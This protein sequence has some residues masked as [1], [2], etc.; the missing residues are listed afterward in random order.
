VQ[1][2]G[3]QFDMDSSATPDKGPLDA[4]LKIVTE[5][6]GLAPDKQQLALKFACETLGI[7]FGAKSVA[8]VAAPQPVEAPLTT[9]PVGPA[10]EDH[11]TDIR[12]FTAM[13]APKSDQQFCAV[14][15]YFYQFESK[16]D[17]RK[18]VI[19]SGTM[20]EAARLAGRPQVVR[21]NMT[22]TNAKN[23]GYL[24]PAGSGKFKL[25]SV[26]ENLV[27]ITLPDGPAVGNVVTR[28]KTKT[29]TKPKTK[30][31]NVKTNKKR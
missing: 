23:A 31:V 8:S 26:G 9:A 25:S 15:A 6:D 28:K 12:T 11:S 2:H 18:D 27:A 17:D 14:V 16:L 20:K 13:K 1:L 7:P 30:P 29:K 4:A 24:D 19:D 22:L 21:W 5:L 10:G 3:K